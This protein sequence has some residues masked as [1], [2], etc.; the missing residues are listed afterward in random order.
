[1]CTLREN[2][3][4]FNMSFYTTDICIII[5]INNIQQYKRHLIKQMIT[6]NGLEKKQIQTN[7]LIDLGL[8]CNSSVTARP[9]HLDEKYHPTNWV[10]SESIDFLHRRDPTK[11][12]FLKMSFVRPHP[13][14]D[15]PQTFYDQYITERSK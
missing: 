11:P 9:W 4:V 15:P 2:Y 10:V 12:F 14:F 13:P 8:D 1:M 7:D 5:A 6:Y 3:V